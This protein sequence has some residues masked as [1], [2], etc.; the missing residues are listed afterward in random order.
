[1][2][3]TH[4]AGKMEK[5]DIASISGGDKKK[6]FSQKLLAGVWIF[7][8]SFKEKHLATSAKI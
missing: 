4:Y 2:L 6:D 1:M 3:Y 5:S 7:A 8:V